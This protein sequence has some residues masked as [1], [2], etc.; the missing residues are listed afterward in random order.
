[1]P[2]FRT[3][4][5]K[6]SLLRDHE[7]SQFLGVVRILVLHSRY[8]SGDLSGE[9]RVVDDEVRLL[10]DAGHDVWTW[11]PSV[12]SDIGAVGRASVGA[13]TVWSRHA[14][15]RVRELIRAHGV[16]LVHVHNLLPMLSPSV[17]RAARGAG[18]NVVAT[19]HNFRLMCL[20]ATLLR[21]GDTCEDC[22][23][24]TPWPGVLHRCYRSSSL[25][26]AAM[27]T[28]L[29][30]HRA[31][32]T[33]RDVTLYL[34]VSEFVREKHIEAGF[35]PERVRVK[36]NFAW[37]TDRR[38]DHGRH[39]LYLGRLSPEKGVRFLLEAWRGFDVPLLI[40]GDGPERE[41]LE[42]LAT[43]DIRFLGAVTPDRATELVRQAR[44]L[45]L[46]S[47]WY[48]GAP[49]SIPEAYAAGVPVIASRIGGIPEFVDDG[50]SGFLIPPA[51]PSAL[52]QAVTR[53][54]S[55]ETSN[56]LAEGAHRVW[57]QRY[58]PTQGLRG[59]EKA[60]AFAISESG[61]KTTGNQ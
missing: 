49:R 16:E 46:P 48:E 11:T 2:D 3:T 38:V 23:G 15:Q 52:R 27:A 6:D 50:R 33:F 59:L 1:M 39:F 13:R 34:A 44:S 54:M 8:L 26:S 47:V 61:G 29:T 7:T 30:V 53:L 42:R 19:L 55:D 17:L 60:Y 31:L 40:A 20:P 51:D 12:R 21:K 25:A 43:G 36:A 22:V 4:S 45:I 10:R 35:A 9:N 24:R 56:E 32:G 58:S 28:S 37:A 5:R 18:V 14:A 57:L 41:H